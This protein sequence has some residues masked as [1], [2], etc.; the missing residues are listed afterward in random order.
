MLDT[1]FTPILDTDDR[2]SDAIPAV[3]GSDAELLDAYSTAVTGMV[4]RVG[5]TVVRVEPR[6]PGAQGRRQG[7][8]SGV[9]ISPMV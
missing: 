3:S 4:E 7:I 2:N 6:Q 8:G 9:I 1:P 5:P